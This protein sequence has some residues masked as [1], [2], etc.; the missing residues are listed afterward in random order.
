MRDRA[1]DRAIFVSV[2][3]SGWMPVSQRG[4]AVTPVSVSHL[5]AAQFLR[6]HNDCQKKKK[7]QGKRDRWSSADM[8]DGSKNG[9]YIQ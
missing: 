8:K 7:I 9:G 3:T 6:A 1:A 2:F 5:L 4:G